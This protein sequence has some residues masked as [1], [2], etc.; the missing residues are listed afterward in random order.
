[1]STMRPLSLAFVLTV[2]AGLSLPAQQ[3]P[4][5]T[6]RVEVNYVEIDAVVTDAQGQFVR[7]LTKDDFEL[8]EEGAVQS[9]TGFTM[10]DLPVERVDPPLFRGTVVDPDVR[11]NLGQ[12]NGR[13]ILIVLDDLQTDVRRSSPV[14]AAARQFVRRFIGVNDLVAV[15]H[16]GSSAGSGQD[17]TNSQPRLLAA[18]DKFFGRKLRRDESA[19]DQERAFK[20]RASLNSLRAS[21]EFLG[22]VRGRRKAVV[23]FGEGIDY[24]IEGLTFA[25][26]GNGLSQPGSSASEIRETLRDV[27]A[28][29][30]RAGVSFYGV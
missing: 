22:N 6:F 1:M 3:R 18:I 24:D 12:F 27:V 10:V 9:I 11:T 2:S 17:F 23:W 29:A 25:G 4:A 28:A 7:D 13:V 16:T 14:R 5:P 30:T 26:S 19:P 8:V 15:A 21:A 20:A